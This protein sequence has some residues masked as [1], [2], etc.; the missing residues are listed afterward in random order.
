MKRFIFCLSV[1][2]MVLT[3][4]SKD[5]EG[6]TSGSSTI[7]SLPDPSDVCSAM[8][9]SVWRQYCYD[10]FDANKDG[11]L[12]QA[13][14]NAVAKIDIRELEIESIK[15]IEYFSNLEDL[16]CSRC[17]QLTSANLSA[18]LKITSLKY[19]FLHCRSLTDII[20]PNSITSIGSFT[21]ADCC[22]LTDITIPNN[23]TTIEELAF[24]C[25]DK[26]TAFYGKYASSDN[27]CLVINGKLIAFAPD[28]LM[29]YT[30]PNNV[31]I[32]GQDVFRN[33]NQLTS[34]IIPNSVSAIG[35]G[36]FRG[37]NNLTSMTIPDNVSSIA[38]DAFWECD[39]LTAFY[40]RYASLDNR[41]LVI[42]GKFVAFAPNGLMEYSIPDGIT[43]IGA[44]FYGC[45]NLVSVTIPT[46]VGSISG[47][48]FSGCDNLA[49]VY[50]KP[51]TPPAL[52]SSYFQIASS[53]KIYVPRSAVEAYK[54]ATHWS[55][56]ADK[57]VG[58]DF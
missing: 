10:N 16:D 8:E 35:I 37:C 5:D 36:A 19:T 52:N 23:V 32:I 45:S 41:G 30:I 14:A 51:L 13:E 31:N 34:V 3:G 21:F 20:L 1:L 42:N 12:S 57:I 7:P 55:Q 38:D 48:P 54:S 27:R 33:Y 58:Y 15:G 56:H 50:C 6:G 46:S 2:G 40:G 47:N 26:L 22:N 29:E 17:W 43:S 44:I 9:D 4:C 25:C 39:K 28:K 53:A 49:N 24:R 11:K 18:N